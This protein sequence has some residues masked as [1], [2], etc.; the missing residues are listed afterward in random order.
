M[1]PSRGNADMQ[2]NRR[3]ETSDAWR[4]GGAEE[5]QTAMGYELVMSGSLMTR[6]Q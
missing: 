4:R 2:M 6:F 1:G 3:N 5:R